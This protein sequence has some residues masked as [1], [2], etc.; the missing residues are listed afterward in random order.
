MFYSG[1]EICPAGQETTTPGH[2]DH[3][4]DPADDDAL[5]GGLESECPDCG[6][7]PGQPCSYGCSSN[8]N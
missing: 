7:Q 2:S 8:W 4:P 3:Q 5:E 1:D 6:A